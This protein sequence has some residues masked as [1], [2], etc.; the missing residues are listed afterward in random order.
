MSDL[1]DIYADLFVI[2]ANGNGVILTA[3][4]FAPP[5]EEGPAQ[6]DLETV[7]R[8]RFTYATAEGLVETLG[9]SI[10]QAKAQIQAATEQA[11][12]KH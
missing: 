4:R 6:N 1:P 10:A 5:E 12:I 7:G 2:N 11:K 9:R 3:R 8:I